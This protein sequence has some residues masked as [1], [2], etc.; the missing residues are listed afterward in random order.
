VFDI[1][2][3]Q[4]FTIIGVSTCICQADDISMSYKFLEY[5]NHSM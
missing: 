3:T 4:L 2:G 5:L 1:V